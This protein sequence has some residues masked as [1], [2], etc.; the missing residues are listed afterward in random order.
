MLRGG[1]AWF[2]ERK[3]RRGGRGPRSLGRVP[4]EKRSEGGEEGENPRWCVF[5]T[6]FSKAFEAFSL[7]RKHPGGRGS[8]HF[9]YLCDA[10][11]AS[12]VRGSEGRRDI[13]F[14]AFSPTTSGSDAMRFCLG[15][16]WLGS[17]PRSG[18]FPLCFRARELIDR[19]RASFERGRWKEVRALQKLPFLSARKLPGLLELPLR[20]ETPSVHFFFSDDRCFAPAHLASSCRAAASFPLLFPCA[21]AQAAF[22]SLLGPAESKDREEQARPLLLRPH[23]FPRRPLPSGRWR[24]AP[25]T[26]PRPRRPP[27]SPRSPASTRRSSGS[28]SSPSLPCR[29]R[30][31]GKRPSSAGSG[32]SSRSGRGEEESR[33]SSC[34]R[35]RRGTS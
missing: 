18:L 15:L 19:E 22:F 13:S 25:P 28:T 32:R 29:A 14:F 4:S 10:E 6:P 7:Q 8:E 11:S 5:P 3:E 12:L 34:G 2:W 23:K 21:R 9:L 26:P 17:P 35:T 20:N 24:S 1:R 27:P 30:P 16:S 33:G 31:R